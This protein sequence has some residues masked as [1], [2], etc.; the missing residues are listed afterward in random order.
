MAPSSVASTHKTCLRCNLSKPLDA[1]RLVSN[2]GAPHKPHTYCLDCERSWHREYHHANKDQRNLKT[3]ERNARR[4]A[5][6]VVPTP[7]E[8]TCRTCGETKP[9]DMF[10]LVS[11]HGAPRIPHSKCSACEHTAKK[12]WEA[13]NLPHRRAYREHYE[14]HKRVITPAR[15]AYQVQWAQENRPRLR[16]SSSLRRARVKGFPSTFTQEEQHFCRAYFHYAC[17]VCGKEEGFQW[18]L[19]MDHWIPINSPH[20]PG[21]VATNMIPLCDGVGGCNT[22][23]QDTLPELWLIKRFGKRKAGA[24]SRK[25]THIL[26]LCVNASLVPLGHLRQRTACGCTIHRIPLRSGCREDLGATLA[27]FFHRLLDI[28]H[29]HHLRPTGTRQFDPAPTWFGL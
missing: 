12:L 1:F 24:F 15:K 26:L 18:T 7:T 20:C 25:L 9:L 8:K 4:R 3:R 19:A 28:N 6:N 17:A 11:N 21:T 23:K 13:K 22:R 27:G 14:A 29:I 16:H 10:R 5:L 2:H